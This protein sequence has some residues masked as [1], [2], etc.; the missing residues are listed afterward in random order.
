[1]GVLAKDYVFV[2]LDTR[3]TRGKEVVARIRSEEGGIPWMVILDAQGQ[4]L[5]T[6]TGPLGNIGHPV[7][8][9]EIAHWEKMLARPPAA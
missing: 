2:K 5:I 1:M 4:P 9:Q 3:Y 6:S 7:I 8:P